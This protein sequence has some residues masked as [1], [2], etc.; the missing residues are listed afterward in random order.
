MARSP[1][2][3]VPARFDLDALARA[4]RARWS[5]LAAAAALLAFLAGGGAGWFGARRF[6]TA[7]ARPAC[8]TA[9]ALDAHRLYVVEVRHP[10]EVPGASARI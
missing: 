7:R 10:V 3:P 9:E 1:S 6:G 2:E 8:V 5:R 4:R